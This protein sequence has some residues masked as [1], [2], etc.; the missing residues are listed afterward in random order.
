MSD[1]ILINVKCNC[2]RQTEYVSVRLADYSK[3]KNEGWS[4]ERAFPY[5]ENGKKYVL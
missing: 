2:C 4:V 3:W 1:K 5:L